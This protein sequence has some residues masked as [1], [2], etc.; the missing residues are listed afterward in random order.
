MD[1][2]AHTR[3]RGAVLG[4]ETLPVGMS[5]GRISAA[6]GAERNTATGRTCRLWLAV[7]SVGLLCAGLV[8]CATPEPPGWRG[9][10]R[11][12]NR[13]AETPSPIPLVER[14][15]FHV[16]PADGTLRSLLARWAADTGMSLAYQHGYDYTLHQAAA[17]VSTTDLHAAADLLTRA[18]AAQGLAVMVEGN[19]IV[20]RAAPVASAPG[21]EA[22]ARAGQ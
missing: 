12:V 17:R 18:Y 11:P 7:A 22:S 4:A 8:S 1:R 16:S 20:V 21:A 14:Y 13:L 19:R 10:W 5:S 15:V 6:H 3:E 9:R 2:G